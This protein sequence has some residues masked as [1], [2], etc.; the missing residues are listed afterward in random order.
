MKL[1][2]P[3]ILKIPVVGPREVPGP[4][5]KIPPQIHERPKDISSDKARFSKNKPRHDGRSW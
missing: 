1:K 5:D 3:S 2:L 4:S